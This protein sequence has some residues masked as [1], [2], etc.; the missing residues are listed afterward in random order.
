M[1]HRFHAGRVQFSQLIDI[2]EHPA[3]ILLGLLLLLIGEFKFGKNAGNPDDEWGSRPNNAKGWM[4]GFKYVP[5]KNVEWNTLYSQQKKGI[6][7]T[8]TD[9]NLFRTEVDFHF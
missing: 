8:E 6:D 1:G 4:L 5:V 2:I 7:A 3:H 9:R